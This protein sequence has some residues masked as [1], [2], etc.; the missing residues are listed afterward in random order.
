MP[1]LRKISVFWIE[2]ESGVGPAQVYD[3]Y[4]WA[5]MF[6]MAWGGESHVGFDRRAY[7]LD[8]I[9]ANAAY[10]NR[11]YNLSGLDQCGQ[12]AT[13][14]IVKGRYIPDDWTLALHYFESR[15]NSQAGQLDAFLSNVTQ[16]EWHPVSPRISGSCANNK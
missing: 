8:A 2:D 14:R 1:E 11:R 3:F 10:F 15:R 4:E 5:S 9:S 16:L 12:Q 6:K 13:L 7:G